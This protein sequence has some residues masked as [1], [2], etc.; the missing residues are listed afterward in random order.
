MD[1]EPWES[2]QPLSQRFDYGKTFQSQNSDTRS[3]NSTEDTESKF[4]NS[5]EING[6]QLMSAPKEPFSIPTQNKRRD[7]SFNR[8]H[9]FK[10]I[11][12]DAK[13]AFETVVD[14][15]MDTSNDT[16]SSDHTD[17]SNS[18]SMKEKGVRFKDTKVNVGVEN[19]VDT[20]MDTSNDTL[21]SVRQDSRNGMSIREKKTRFKV[22]KVDLG[23]E[24]FHKDVA[25][26]KM[27]VD[28]SH[29]IHEDNRNLAKDILKEM[30][31]K[32]TGKDGI[33]TSIQEGTLE[34]NGDQRITDH[35][36]N[37]D[38]TTKVQDIFSP[39]VNPAYKTIASFLSKH[40]Y[41]KK[42]L[43]RVATT[44]ESVLLRNDSSKQF[45]AFF[46][47]HFVENYAFFCLK[48]EMLCDRI[49]RGPEEI[50]HSLYIGGCQ[51]PSLITSIVISARNK[52]ETSHMDSCFK[53]RCPYK[54]SYFE[55]RNL[56][57]D[58]NDTKPDACRMCSYLEQQLTGEELHALFQFASYHYS[59]FHKDLLELLRDYP[60]VVQQLIAEERGKVVVFQ[61]LCTNGPDPF[62][63][64]YKLGSILHVKD[65]EDENWPSF[66]EGN[67][68]SLWYC[69]LLFRPYLEGCS[70]DLVW[71]KD[72]KSLKIF[73][74]NCL[75]S[76][77][78]TK[79]VFYWHEC[80]YH[81][82]DTY[83]RKYP[84]FEIKSQKEKDSEERQDSLKT[85]EVSDRHTIVLGKED[86]DYDM[87]E[88]NEI[89]LMYFNSE[90][91]TFLCEKGMEM[92][93][94]SRIHDVISKISF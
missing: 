52:V 56:M 13:D 77:T 7:S 29:D 32:I 65:E 28:Y 50:E 71:E 23:I 66:A 41:F 79:D 42:T 70:N 31:S 59:I 94:E 14:T 40:D 9:S 78:F 80:K 37:E 63:S 2:F 44:N 83:V 24:I 90:S 81:Y 91:F 16:F 82:Y 17:S 76:L 26:W 61:T 62:G 45:L 19:V 75:K 15:S 11:P 38:D 58:I 4:S 64:Y 84:D 54:I 22:T 55:L 3:V 86:P 36:E 60:T 5:S 18:V 27:H 1:S 73:N 34:N 53:Q 88:T 21:S 68:V 87:K 35:K 20:S 67:F 85:N 25:Q 57:C 12:F 49:G 10:L 69:P 8:S 51:I 74:W 30:R 46:L 93:T 89:Y 43:H 47:Q 72:G 39:F 33:G 48:H 92:N 6:T